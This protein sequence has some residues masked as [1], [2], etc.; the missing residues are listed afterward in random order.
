MSFESYKKNKTGVNLACYLSYTGD[1]SKHIKRRRWKNINICKNIA[2]KNSIESHKEWRNFVM[3][4]Q[5]YSLPKYPNEVF[6]KQ[7]KGWDDFLGK[8]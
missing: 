4:S 5:D 3:K 6:Q 1:L 2:K 8:K 7:W